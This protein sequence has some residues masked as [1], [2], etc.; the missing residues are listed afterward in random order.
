MRVRVADECMVLMLKRGERREERGRRVLKV[1]QYEANT[2]LPFTNFVIQLSP[3]LLFSL[4]PFPPDAFRSITISILV[5]HR[6]KSIIPRHTILA[7]AILAVTLTTAKASHPAFLIQPSFKTTHHTA[8][9]RRSPSSF[10]LHQST[11]NDPNNHRLRKDGPKN[12]STSRNEFSRTIR[13]SKWFTSMSGGASS[14]SSSKSRNKSLNFSISADDSE[15]NALASRFRL[16]NITVL[17]A[18][19]VVSPALGLSGGGGADSE[20]CIE[21]RGTVST[22]VKQTCVRTNEDFDVDMEFNFD[23]TLKAMAST[24]SSSGSVNSGSSGGGGGYSSGEL[25]AL[26]AA[27]QF[28][29]RRGG[30]GGGKRNNRKQTTVK[31]VKGSQKGQDV[32]IKELQNILTGYEVTNDIIEDESCFCTD[33]IVDV[34]EIVSQMFRSKL[35]PYPKKPGSDPVKYTFTF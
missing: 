31:T 4:F 17:E 27:A 10:A 21:V 9:I 34:G 23:T 26:A 3:L 32:D 22:K 19:L 29:S 24:T 18:D 20:S 25:E 11:N 35:D 28:E 8:S 1:I 5:A 12:E 30:G 6:M 33:G 14:S 2:H 7:A 13:V 16:A 15:R